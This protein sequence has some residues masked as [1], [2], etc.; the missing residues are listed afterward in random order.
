MKWKYFPSETNLA[1]LTNPRKEI[2]KLIRQAKR[3]EEMRVADL[4]KETQKSFF[5]YVN[6]RKSIR[7]KIVQL[8]DSEGILQT[9]DEVKANI[10]NKYFASVFTKENYST[11]EPKIRFD[12]AK[13]C[14]KYDCL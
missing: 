10:F 5:F 3:I 14:L 6:N 11:P 9:D 1:D 13:E 2:K 4:S 7:C 8:K 12:G